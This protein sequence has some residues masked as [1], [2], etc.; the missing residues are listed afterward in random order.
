MEIRQSTS[1]I[2]EIKSVASLLNYKI[3]RLC[4]Y[5]NNPKDAISYFKNHIEIFQNKFVSNQIEFE[6]YGWLSKQFR[7]F[8]ELFDMAVNFFNLIP[9]SN[10]HPG[11]YY[12]ESATYL[13]KRRNSS[14]LFNHLKKELNADSFDSNVNDAVNVE[15]IGHSLFV[16]GEFSI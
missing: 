10:H 8:A 11:I 5:L 13:V 12:F 2:F 4:F 14:K 1:N 6:H 9:T 7:M 16:Q 3:C 15:F